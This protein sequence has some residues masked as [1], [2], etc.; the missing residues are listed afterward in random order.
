M[1]KKMD[2]TED[3]HQWLTLEITYDCMFASGGLHV[4]YMC[5]VKKVR[6]VMWIYT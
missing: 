4:L 5:Y 6:Q 3:P 2:G 1:Q